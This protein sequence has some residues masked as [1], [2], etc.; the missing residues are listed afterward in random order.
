MHDD[1]NEP[2][3]TPR[4]GMSTKCIVQRRFRVAVKA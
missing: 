3:T 4:G 2:A 1:R